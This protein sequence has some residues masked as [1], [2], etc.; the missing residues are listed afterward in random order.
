MSAAVNAS[1][2]C[3]FDSFLNSLAY[4]FSLGLGNI[5][6]QL[7]NNIGNQRSRQITSGLCI[8]QRHIQYHNINVFFFRQNPP[9]LQ[10]FLIITSKPINT[11][12]YKRVSLLQFFQKLLI[13][14]TLKILAGLFFNDNACRFYPKTPRMR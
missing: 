14:R 12:D 2:L 10:N 8:Q 11:Y 1:R 7:Q 13:Q 5:G 6:Q 9:L 3:C 4:I